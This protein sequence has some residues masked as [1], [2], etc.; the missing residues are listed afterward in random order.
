M[1][2]ATRHYPPA[3]A[4]MSTSDW[5]PI[6]RAS[7]PELRE[8]RAQAHHAVQWLAKAAYAYIRNEPDH[9]HSNL[10]WD[11]ALGGLVTHPV[12]RGTRLAVKFSQL[13][14]ALL[15]ED[16]RVRGQFRLA[17]RTEA[18]VR[19]WLGSELRRLGLDAR[20]LDTVP[21]PYEITKHAIAGGAPY[22]V[23]RIAQPLEE[24]AA[25]FANADRVLGVVRAAHAAHAS[26]V[27]CWP[28]HFDLA[29]LITLP[30][31]GAKTGRSVNAGLSPGDHYYDEPY[32]YISPWP[33]PEAGRL[34]ALPPLGHWHTHEFTAAV[35][36]ASRILQAK[37]PQGESE[38]FVRA[39]VEGVMKALR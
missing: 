18:D 23:Q 34:P 25:W 13:S 11:D 16:G 20:L 5:R 8:A 7:L 35:A 38:A 19:N 6:G 4:I 37:D 26:P 29:T 30:D 17:G 3:R 33:Y 27:R 9:S 15:G 32:Y 36:A 12:A 2:R 1:P 10:G 22:S 28:H 39:A 24:L 31:E 14:L 21:L